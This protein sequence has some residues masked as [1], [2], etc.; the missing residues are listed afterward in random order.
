MRTTIL[1]KPV[2]L[3]QIGKDATSVELQTSISCEFEREM[4]VI[5]LATDL[6]ED[7]QQIGMVSCPNDD[8]NRLVDRQ[9][10]RWAHTLC[11]LVKAWF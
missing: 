4:Q 2:I 10:S 5:F 3:L 7:N 1:E 9:A 8:P 6:F 11:A